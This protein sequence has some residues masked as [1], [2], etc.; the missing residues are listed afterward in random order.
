MS[1]Q[2][3]LVAAIGQTKAVIVQCHA[4]NHE[5]A[6]MAVAALFLDTY[7]ETANAQC[8]DTGAAVG[9]WIE[10]DPAYIRSVV[11]GHRA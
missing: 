8:I 3:Y 7:G 6:N 1:Q 9:T 5:E 4:H 2:S 11:E 10:G